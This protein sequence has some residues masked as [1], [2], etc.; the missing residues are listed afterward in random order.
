VNA[1]PISTFA[2]EQKSYLEGKKK[3][4]KTRSCIESFFFRRFLPPTNSQS[5]TATRFFFF[6]ESVRE[7][8][9]E[10]CSLR[11]A[12]LPSNLTSPPHSK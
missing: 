4:P 2:H 3:K 12:F 8:A 10:R 9:R 5:E 11:E 7:D 6:S 1:S